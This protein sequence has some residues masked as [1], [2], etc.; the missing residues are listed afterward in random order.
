MSHLAAMACCNCAGAAPVD[1]LVDDP[2]VM[3]TVVKSTIMSISPILRGQTGP[4]RR[5]TSGVMPRR[6]FCGADELRQ[7]RAGIARAHFLSTPPARRGLCVMHRA[8]HLFIANHVAVSIGPGVARNARKESCF[9]RKWQIVSPARA[10]LRCALD[11]RRACE[12][13]M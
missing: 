7:R 6:C 1:Q 13:V 9:L 2:I 11:W 12:A 3:P 4:G 5:P 8:R 10:A